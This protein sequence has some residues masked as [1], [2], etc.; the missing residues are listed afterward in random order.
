MNNR[1][2]YLTEDHPTTTSLVKRNGED[3]ALLE[4]ESTFE[5]F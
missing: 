1:C 3:K 4:G 5:E 2:H